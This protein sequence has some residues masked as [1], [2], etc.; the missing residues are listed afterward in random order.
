MSAEGSAHLYITT[1]VYVRCKILLVIGDKMTARA[2]TK[3]HG[4]ALS[5]HF[6]RRFLELNSLKHGPAAQVHMMR[7]AGANRIRSSV[8]NQLVTHGALACGFVFEMSTAQVNTLDRFSPIG[9]ILH[10]VQRQFRTFNSFKVTTALGGL[11]LGNITVDFN[12]NHADEMLAHGFTVFI[13]RFSRFNADGLGGTS[14]V[15]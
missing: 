7:R 9:L 5:T 15:H 2:K 11:V 4:R 8:T 1:S 6:Q 13:L 10:H 12:V 14:A 3:Q